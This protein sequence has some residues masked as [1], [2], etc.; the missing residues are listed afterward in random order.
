MKLQYSLLAAASLL[1]TV[2]TAHA[3]PPIHRTS[4]SVCAFESD[5]IGDYVYS[6]GGVSNASGNRT[7]VL[8]CP[9][10]DPNTFSDIAVDGYDAN[11]DPNVGVPEARI[12]QTENWGVA[13]ACSAAA[14]LLAGTSTGAFSTWLPH[15]LSDG[16]RD[17]ARY[18]WYADLIIS[19][20]RTGAYGQSTIYG[21][22]GI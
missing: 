5:Y 1:L 18:N 9:L 20:P 13:V 3:A 7:R 15:Y 22:F 10:F 19:I 6:Y 11:S 17:P 4:V 14:P 21:F 2:G 16:L 8:H 12:C